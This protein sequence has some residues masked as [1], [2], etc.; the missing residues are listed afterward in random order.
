MLVAQGCNPSIE[1]VDRGIPASLKPLLATRRFQR[2]PG[3]HVM[4]SQKHI[5]ILDKEI[6]LHSTAIKTTCF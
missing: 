4:L 3:K 2:Q 5:T 1:E 6:I